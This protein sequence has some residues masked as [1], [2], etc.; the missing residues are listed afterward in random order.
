MGTE[1]VRPSARPT[2]RLS[3]EHDT[4]TARAL[5]VSTEVLRDALPRRISLHR[6]TVLACVIA[7]PLN[8]NL[9]GRRS[10]GTRTVSV[11]RL[12]FPHAPVLEMQ[13]DTTITPPRLGHEPRPIPTQGI[14]DLAVHVREGHGRVLPA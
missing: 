5:A 12:R 11:T 10:F 1:M 13:S 2:L 8:A 4:S 3:A 9:F 6:L 14:A 7:S